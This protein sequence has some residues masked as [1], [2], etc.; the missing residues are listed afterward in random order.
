MFEFCKIMTELSDSHQ[1]EPRLLW[2]PFLMTLSFSEGA[3]S[4][5]PPQYAIGLSVTG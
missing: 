1:E 3:Q 4:V 5:L 2:G